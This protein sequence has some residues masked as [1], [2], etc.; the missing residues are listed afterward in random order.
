MSALTAWRRSRPASLFER[1][2]DGLATGFIDESDDLV[3]SLKRNLQAILNTR[4]GNAQSCLELG[5]TDFN[6]AIGSSV[7]VYTAICTA[8]RRCIEDYEPRISKAEVI[9]RP[10]DNDP[11]TLF[12]LIKAYVFF[13]DKESVINFNLRIDGNHKYKLD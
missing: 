13:E 6:D 11:L 3:A 4:P 7:E 8:I 9:A 1:I 12:F 2:E 5:I 10:D